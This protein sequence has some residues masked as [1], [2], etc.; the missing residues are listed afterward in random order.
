MSAPI[1]STVV[2]IG[3]TEKSCV[4]VSRV[5]IVS[6]GRASFYAGK[7][8]KLSTEGIV[9]CVAPFLASNV[10]MRHVKV[11]RPNFKDFFYLGASW[12]EPFFF[13]DIFRLLCACYAR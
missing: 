1:V 9:S 6:D 7:A 5:E 12:F 4:I 8:S 3:V 13:L 2:D 10:K 11:A